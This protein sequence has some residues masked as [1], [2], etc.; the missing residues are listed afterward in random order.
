M[1]VKGD[2]GLQSEGG[3]EE[4]GILY[5]VVSMEYLI[6]ADPDEAPLGLDFTPQYQFK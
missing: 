5:K 2:V 1:R 4:E 3:C 6:K